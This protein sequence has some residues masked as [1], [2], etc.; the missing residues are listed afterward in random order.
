MSVTSIWKDAAGIKDRIVTID[1]SGNQQAVSLIYIDISQSEVLQHYMYLSRSSNSFGP[2]RFA[3]ELVLEF[4]VHLVDELSV[5][6]WA[7]SSR[8]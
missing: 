4:L 6:D 5:L 1:C 2:L 7:K 3:T 8:S